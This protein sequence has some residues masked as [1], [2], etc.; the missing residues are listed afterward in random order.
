MSTENLAKAS[1]LFTMLL[2]SSASAQTTWYV[3][4][5]GTSPGTG[6][7]T[8]PFTSIQYAIDQVTTVSGDTV[9]VAPGT[10]CENVQ[11]LGKVLQLES[12]GGPE[13]TT[14]VGCQEGAVVTMDTVWPAYLKGF[15]VTGAIGG[16]SSGVT[17]S[18]AGDA[19]IYECIIRGNPRGVESLFDLHMY[20]S[21]LVGNG[22]GL[23]SATHIAYLWV[24]NS[25]FWNNG[26]DL[27]GGGGIISAFISTGVDP[28]FWDEDNLDFRLRHGSPCIDAG[29]PT[30]TDPDG[31]ILDIGALVHDPTYAPA[32]T[33]FCETAP[34]SVGPGCL[35]SSQGSVSVTTNDFTLHAA[36]APASK[37]GLF[38]YGP[39][40][41]Q[42]PFGNGYLCVSHQAGIGLQ[43]LS[44]PIVTD[45]NGDASR[46][47]DFSS[48]PASSGASAIQAGSTWYFQ[49]WYRDSVGAGFNLSDGLKASYIP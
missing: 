1:L 41:T 18:L 23:H 47:V 26:T 48:G 15:T 17:S 21:T 40:P 31:S 35:I 16:S 42:F 34:N 4:A 45:M 37:P 27:T 46:L 43:R 6:T 22:E 8:D 19:W 2:A 32:A 14:I 33:S 11:F 9:E 24:E 12:R 25:V 38:F 28:M 36:G 7:I 30:L 29:D 13:V 5:A 3:D 49:L 10:Y 20:S 39:L 44:P